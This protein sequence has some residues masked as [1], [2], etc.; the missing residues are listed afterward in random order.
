MLPNCQNFCCDNLWKSIIMA[1]EK[2]GKLIFF[3]LTLWPPCVIIPAFLE[4][5]NF[6]DL[7]VLAV[8]AVLAGFSQ[9]HIISGLNFHLLTV[10]K[11][12]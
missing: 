3:S 1:L 7:I 6:S 2:P 8:L 5:D 12:I 11:Y 10:R 4:G 9:T